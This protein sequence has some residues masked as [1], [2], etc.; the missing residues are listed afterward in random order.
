MKNNLG[1]YAVKALT[2]MGVIYVAIVVLLRL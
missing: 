1:E 2:F